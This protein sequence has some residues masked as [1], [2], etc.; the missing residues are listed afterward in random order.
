MTFS[1]LLSKLAAV[2]WQT[3]CGAPREFAK[4][5]SDDVGLAFEDLQIPVGGSDRIHAWWIPAAKPVATV[6]LVFQGNGDVLQNMLSSE[7][8]GLHATGARLLVVDYRGWPF[9]WDSSAGE[10]K[11]F[12]SCPGTEAIVPG[13]GRGPRRSGLRGRRSTDAGFAGVHSGAAFGFQR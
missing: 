13:A 4:T 1:S 8:P 9:Y 11:S 7:I 12:R 6:I 2:A 5:D 10:P 3:V